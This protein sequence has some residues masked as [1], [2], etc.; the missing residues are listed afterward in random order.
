[1][2]N[3]QVKQ[4]YNLFLFQNKTQMQQMLSDMMRINKF[5]EKLK[6]WNS[7]ELQQ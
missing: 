3:E 2:K 4:L 7:I 1:M 5:K 6:K